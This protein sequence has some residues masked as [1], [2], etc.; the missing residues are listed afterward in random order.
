MSDTTPAPLAGD[1]PIA[2]TT[3]EAARQLG[4]G[5]DPQPR[6]LKMHWITDEELDALRVGS[7]S[8]PL[9]F[10]GLAVGL[11]VAFCIALSNNLNSRTHAAYQA[12]SIAF[13]VIALLCLFIAVGRLWRGHRIA[14]KIRQWP[15][16]P[17]GPSS[18]G[19]A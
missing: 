1:K 4:L 19:D 9:T 16:N 10:F 3:S 13:A 7:A 15:V 8:L 11:S 2:S 12:L 14:Q 17:S 6:R 5:F 18:T